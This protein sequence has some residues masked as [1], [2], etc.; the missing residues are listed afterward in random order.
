M[1][2]GVVISNR[3]I[4][5]FTMFDEI[6]ADLELKQTEKL[7]LGIKGIRKILNYKNYLV[8][9][10]IKSIIILNYQDWSICIRTFIFE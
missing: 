7:E 2:Y 3:T 8:I 10:T 6:I 1:S 4:I 9:N 5:F